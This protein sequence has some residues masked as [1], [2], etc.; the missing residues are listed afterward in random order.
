MDVYEETTCHPVD[1]AI[2][3]RGGGVVEGGGAK[4]P[5]ASSYCTPPS[6]TADLRHMPT[7]QQSQQRVDSI[8]NKS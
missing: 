8:I 5:G 1:Y 3:R 6:S 4:K 7:L 2:R